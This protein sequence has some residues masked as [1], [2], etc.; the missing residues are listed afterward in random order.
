[1]SRNNLVLKLV[2]LVMLASLILA[3]CAPAATEAP[4]AEPTE[5]AT[6]A[7]TAE[8]TMEPPVELTYTYPGAIP[9][10]VASVE[11]A[12]SEITLEKFNATIKLNPVD[13][14]AY[15]DKVNLMVAAGEGCDILFVAPWMS[16]SYSQ[17]VSTGAL[18]PLNDLLAGVPELV[19]SMPAGALDATAI[20][21]VTYGIPNQQIWVKPF[22][23]MV[24]SDL[25]EKY[26]FDISTVAKLEDLEPYLAAVEAGET[27]VYPSTQGVFRNELFGWD[28]IVSEQAG[29]VVK[30]DDAGLAVINA[31]ETAEFAAFAELMRKWY[32]AGYFPNDAVTEDELNADWKAGKYGASL[33]AVV[34]PGLSAEELNK[35]GYAV[36]AQALAPAF[37]TTGSVTATMNAVCQ[38]SASPE[39]SL[40]FLNLVN[41][42]PV[43][44]NILAKGVEGKQWVWTDEAAKIIG[45]GPEKEAYNPGSDWMFGNT[46]NAYYTDADSAKNQAETAAINAGA[47]PSVALGFTF[48]PEPVKNEIA[49]VT[50]VVAE[51]GTPIFSG[52]VDPATALPE[53]IQALKDAGIDKVIAEVQ[54][55]LNAFAGK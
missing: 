38:T 41:T 47:T 20:D 42:D 54:A 31:Y 8:P 16:P 22:G 33:L 43:F 9:S 10:D 23:P 21:G 45:D 6:E 35:R 28:P 25:A 15:T 5:A 14:G 39:K 48:N 4:A 36:D 27:D 17:L 49:L 52:Y 2:T 29:V 44:Y 53:F 12:L 19:D 55:Q 30:Y 1:M 13:W 34:K 7:P 37:T 24:R 11:A 40:A 50:A 3:A 46:F 51:K 26:A 32:E 18:Y